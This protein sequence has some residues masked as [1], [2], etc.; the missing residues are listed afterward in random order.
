LE[1]S[2]YKN[3][4]ESLFDFENIVKNKNEVPIDI[5]AYIGDSF[6]NLIATFISIKDG[7][8]RTN[9]ANRRGV[10]LK[11]ASGQKKLL[12]E[13]MD[14][15]TEDEKLIVKK[16]LNSKGAKKRGN[17]VDYRQATAFETLLGYLFLNKN[18]E[19]LNDIFRNHAF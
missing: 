1:I 17:D 11:R 4:L 8:V 9:E 6:F 7:R 15:L 3:S 10:K 12:E 5:Y 13:C 18:W 2:K 14:I 19:R 16:G